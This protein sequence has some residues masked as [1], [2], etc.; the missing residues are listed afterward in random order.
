M[1]KVEVFDP[2]MCCSTGVCGPNVDPTLVRFA[3]DLHWLA[4]SGWR[5]NDTTSRSSPRG[6]Q[7]PALLMTTR[8]LNGIPVDATRILFF[9]GKGGVGK[10]SLAW[11]AAVSL[12]QRG[13]KVL[14]VSTAA[15]VAT[16]I[17]GAVPNLSVSRIDPARETCQYTETMMAKS[18]PHLDAQGM[19]LLEEDLRSPRTEEIAV[20]SAFARTVAEGSGPTGSENW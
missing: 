18:A 10:T 17:G 15:H 12:A 13:K 9:T 19:A 5:S 20:S 6:D 4:N 1:K 16:M 8:G 7:F 14:L 3:A 11:A 2:P